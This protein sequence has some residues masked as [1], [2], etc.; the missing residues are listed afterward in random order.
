MKGEVER[1]TVAKR[2][3]AHDQGTKKSGVSTEDLPDLMNQSKGLRVNYHLVL[4]AK[5]GETRSL[6]LPG[7]QPWEFP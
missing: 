3:G 1:V 4:F 6:R 5:T 2:F 7:V